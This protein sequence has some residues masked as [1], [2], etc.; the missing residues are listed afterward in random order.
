MYTFAQPLNRAL[1][2][3]AGSSAVVC[4]C[5][6]RKLGPAPQDRVGVVVLNSDRYLELYLAVFGL[7]GP[8]WGSRSTRSCSA[9]RR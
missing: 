1:C 3:A 2:T 8:R 9:G 6:M 7:P 4:Q 5:P